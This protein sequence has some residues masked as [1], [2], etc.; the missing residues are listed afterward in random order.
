MSEH[1]GRRLLVV[2]LVIGATVAVVLTRP[3]RL[4]LDLKGGTQIVLEAQDTATKT[5]EEKARTVKGR[6]ALMAEVNRTKLRPALEG[7]GIDWLPL[8][9]ASPSA[10][11][12]PDIED[13][14]EV[15]HPG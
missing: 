5:E 14:V 1:L 8:D 15:P 4:G 6:D 11:R 7:L 13:I 9:R 10:G 12:P 3:V 2:V